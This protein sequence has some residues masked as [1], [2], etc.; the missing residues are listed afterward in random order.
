ME[1]GSSGNHKGKEKSE[2]DGCEDGLGEYDVSRLKDR[3]GSYK[4]KPNRIDMRAESAQI[5]KR[6]RENHLESIRKLER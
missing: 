6:N 1:L 5:S 4:E 3:T 2:T